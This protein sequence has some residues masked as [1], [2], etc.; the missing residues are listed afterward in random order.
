MDQLRGSAGLLFAAIGIVV[1]WVATR[2]FSFEPSLPE[3]TESVES[4]RYSAPALDR[5][6]DSADLESRTA[7]EDRIRRLQAVIRSQREEIQAFRTARARLNP[8]SDSLP[9]AAS[10]PSGGLL[11]NL[12]DLSALTG[13]DSTGLSADEIA[14]RLEDVR[15]V[16]IELREQLQA[17]ESIV[18]M[19][20]S[21]IEDLREE[22]DITRERAAD[23]VVEREDLDETISRMLDESRELEA[24][25]TRVLVSLGPAAAPALLPLLE[26][27]RL[28]VR[29]WV[30]DLMELIS[31]V[32]E[33]E[34]PGGDR[35]P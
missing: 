4:R 22:L 18:E 26:D 24:A 30:R 11:A 33:E 25:A 5:L 20:T 23:L 35:T 29:A 7:A 34:E 8:G 14:A 16:A 9:P 21:E 13:A 28:H 2:M 12:P 10:R 1:V 31:Q 15:S 3:P 17:A 6:P 32:P 27:P 19:Q